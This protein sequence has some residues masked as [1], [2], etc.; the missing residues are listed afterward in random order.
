MMRGFGGNADDIRG[1]WRPMK[2]KSTD[3]ETVS[4]MRFISSAA[5]GKW[6]H[7]LALE[8]VIPQVVFMIL[9]RTTPLCGLVLAGGRS[10]RM[11]RDKSTLVHPDGRT[12][13]RR[14]CDLL[15]EAGCEMVVL[16]LRHDQEVPAELEG[17][18]VVRDPAGDSVGPMAGIV[19]GMKLRPDADWLV[20]ACDLPRLDI[21]TL[22]ALIDSK[23]TDEKFLAYRSEFDGLPEPL[24]ALYG[25]NSLPLLE[26]ALANDF[27]CPRKILMRGDCRLIEPTTQRALENANTPDDWMTATQELPSLPQM[28]GELLEI[29]ISEGN[30]FR[31]RHEKG[32]LSHEIRSVPEV[33]CVAGMGL[34]G[35]RY[36]GFKEDFKGQVT[37][38][39]AA[40]VQG[41]R[42][43]FNLP[44]LPSSVFR[45]NLIVS[46]VRLGDW[47]GKKF[48]FQDIEFEGTEECKPCYWMD[49]V[50]APGAEEF[51]KKNFRGGLRARIITS[52]TLKVRQLA[53]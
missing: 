14:T 7:L 6:E 21:A 41:V 13:V 36:F 51:M 31:G 49:D 38:F 30:D 19:G 12:L 45:R 16:S 9:Q 44:D 20:L 46:G 23:Q 43:E 28:D 37:F 35:D 11:G 48:R 50:A 33:E 32:R 25:P 26:D 18:P 39:D 17:I 3:R 8:L 22:R 4:S 53:E 27:R 47:V 10:S 2:E 15:K 42:E 1:I 24:C 5:A 29:W 40:A 52:G 34:R